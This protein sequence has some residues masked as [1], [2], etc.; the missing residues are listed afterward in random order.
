MRGQAVSVP[1]LRKSR[2]VALVT[3]E[4]PVVVCSSF[5]QVYAVDFYTES[6][7]EPIQSN[8]QLEARYAYIDRHNEQRDDHFLL[9]FVEFSRLEQFAEAVSEDARVAAFFAS[10]G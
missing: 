8:F 4:F 6:P 1:A 10:P 2:R 9:D 7:P 5:D 3:I